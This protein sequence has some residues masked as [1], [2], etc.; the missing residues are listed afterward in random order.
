MKWTDF[1]PVEASSGL[2]TFRIV[3]VQRFIGLHRLGQHLRQPTSEP[4]VCDRRNTKPE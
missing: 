3:F 1:K 2:M 4:T